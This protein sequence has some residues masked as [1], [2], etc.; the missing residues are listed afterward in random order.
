M[1]IPIKEENQEIQ[2]IN[3]NNSIDRNA[4][5]SST[6]VEITHKSIN[7]KKRKQSSFLKNL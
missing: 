6:T 1:S 5:K 4:S 3:S 2:T 7:V